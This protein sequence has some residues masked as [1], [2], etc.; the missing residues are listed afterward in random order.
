MHGT[1]PSTIGIV[2][3]SSPVALLAWLGEKFRDW[4]D[5]DL[6]LDQVLETVTLWWVLECFPKAIYAY[7]Q[8][9][10]A[11]LLPHS[12]S[13]L[14][15]SSFDSCLLRL[16]SFVELEEVR[17]EVENF[18]TSFVPLRYFLFFFNYSSPQE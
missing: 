12:L 6:N 14:S 5:D 7:E 8:V 11:F 13:S 4:T 9:S 1:R 10:T 3:Q 2:V 17:A 15:L 18:L 16:C